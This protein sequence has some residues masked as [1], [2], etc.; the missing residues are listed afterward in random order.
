MQEAELEVAM[1]KLA[2]AKKA[3]FNTDAEMLQA[4]NNLVELQKSFLLDQ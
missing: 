4:G 2:V 1:A 3:I